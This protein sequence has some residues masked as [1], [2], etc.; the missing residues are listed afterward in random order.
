MGRVVEGRPDERRIG[1]HRQAGRRQQDAAGHQR[2]PGRPGTHEPHRLRDPES[3]DQ[4]REVVRHLQMV[5]RKVDR[6][7]RTRQARAEPQVAAV[8]HEHPREDAG[9]RGDGH[10]LR[11][12]ARPEVEDVERTE[13]KP[14]RHQH[15][16]PGPATEQRRQQV[17]AEQGDQQV[18][19][20]TREAEPQHL[21]KPRARIDVLRPHPE[22]E[23]GHAPKLAVGP[24]RLLAGAVAVVVDLL[25]RRGEVLDV[26]HPQAVPVKRLRIEGARHRSQQGHGD[27]VRQEGTEELG[28]V[29][30]VAHAAQVRTGT[31]ACHR[32]KRSFLPVV[33][34]LELDVFTEVVVL[35]RLL[36]PGTRTGTRV[37]S[38][39]TP[40]ARRR[41]TTPPAKQAVQ[42]AEDEPRHDEADQR[43][44]QPRQHYLER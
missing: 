16:D 34:F 18:V 13:S 32:R 31:P 22:L 43:P 26:R 9:Q 38:R 40:P 39:G 28:R 19:R 2:P 5:R 24:E 17:G 8:R 20:R 14:E 27:E 15:R 1:H 44:E 12:V 30:T 4:K 21:A 11:R 33:H 41:G 37:P 25:G 7:E 6:G 35:G 23:G 36:R 3:T 10:H 29:R 42:E